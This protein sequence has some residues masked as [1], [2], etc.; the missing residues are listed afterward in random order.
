[1]GEEVVRLAESGV[2]AASGPLRV[3]GISQRIVAVRHDADLR[4]EVRGAWRASARR[5]ATRL[6]GAAL[7]RG[8]RAR[9]LAAPLDA[10]AAAARR[11]GMLDRGGSF[12]ADASH[13]RRTPLT[14]LR[15]DLEALA[16]TGADPEL[17]AAAEA[18]A[19]RLEATITEL[20]DL[21]AAPAG[22]EVVDVARLVADRIGAWE[23]L[24]AAAGRRVVVSADPAPAVRVRAAAL[25]QSLQVLLDNALEHG[26]GTITVSVQRLRAAGDG[27]AR[28]EEWVRLCVA[29]EGPGIP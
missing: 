29:D 28:D 25:G 13:Q 12:G 4:R 3:G 6:G 14:A 24:A 5:A 21:A 1:S 2:V 11:A 15:L 8:W 9:R 10:V 23:S 19:D 26:Q 27:A 20:L 17:L 16:A 18:E 22:E 7:V